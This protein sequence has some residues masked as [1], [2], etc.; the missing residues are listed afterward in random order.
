MILE[1]GVTTFKSVELAPFKKKKITEFPFYRC[2]KERPHQKAPR[3]GTPGF[4]PPEVLLKSAKQ[5]TAVDLWAAG[6]VFLCMLARSYPF[7]R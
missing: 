5:N 6:I 7:F 4:R 1:L 2:S 3:A